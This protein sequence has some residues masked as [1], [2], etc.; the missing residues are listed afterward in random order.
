VSY[1]VG[2]VHEMMFLQGPLNRRCF[3]VISGHLVVL[4]SNY[5][6]LMDPTPEV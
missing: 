2:D 5:Q 4:R 6:A 3:D 1:I